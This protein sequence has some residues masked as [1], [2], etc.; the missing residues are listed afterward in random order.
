MTA[1]MLTGRPVADALWQQTAASVAAVTARVGRPPQLAIVLGTDPAARAYATQVERSFHRHGLGARSQS[2]AG[3]GSALREV[4][5]RLSADAAV[6]GV[7]VVA[8]LPGGIA[9]S[10]VVGAIDPAKD[11]DGQHPENLGRLVLRRS[12][13]APA[14]AVGGL[15]LLQHYGVPISGRRA[16]VVGRSSVV[17][18]PLALLLLGANATVTVCHSGTVDLERQTRQAEILCVAIGKAAT[19]GPS[20]VAPGATVLDFGTNA[21]ED[22]SLVGDVQADALLEVAAA[23]TP[24]PQGTGPVTTAVLAE[25]TTAAALARSA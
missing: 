12:G 22:G 15:R 5:K 4:L 13:L 23:V 21:Q 19:I 18:M 2:V 1:R 6:D 3:D 10:A 7:L 25:Q 17:G 11:V 14:T 8:P 20:Y 24:V 16:V 9:I